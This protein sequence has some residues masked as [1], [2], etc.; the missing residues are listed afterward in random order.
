LCY[1]DLNHVVFILIVGPRIWFSGIY[2]PLLWL[3]FIG[4]IV[5]VPF[6]L[7]HKKY[8][9]T[10]WLKHIH[11]PIL[12]MPG[13][14]WYY[15]SSAGTFTWLLF[16]VLSHLVIRRWWY[17]HYSLLFSIAMDTGA[18]L[19]GTVMLFLFTNRN[20]QYPEWWGSSNNDTCPLASRA[21]LTG[22]F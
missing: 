20:I 9:R 13:A 17:E 12:L 22:P 16:G 2:K 21:S 7:L 3:L 4:I 19:S 11:T 14:Y 8:T 5:P 6:W 18:T 15:T 1:S 10:T